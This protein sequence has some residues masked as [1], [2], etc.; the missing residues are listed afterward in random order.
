MTPVVSAESRKTPYSTLPN[1]ALE[2][3]GLDGSY[4]LCAQN[5]AGA[6]SAPHFV[7]RPAPSVS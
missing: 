2:R 4:A 5:N 7:S 6:H 3:P 1:V